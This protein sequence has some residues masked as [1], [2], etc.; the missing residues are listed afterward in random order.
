[1]SKQISPQ[2][3]QA[4]VE[5]WLKTPINTYLGSSY[6]FNK[7]ALL[8]QPLSTATIDEV[9]DKLKRDVPILNVLDSGAINIF[10]IPIPPARMALYLQVGD[11]KFS[12]GVSN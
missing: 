3:I 12:L 10:S 4:M 11:L 8:F 7:S 5:H 2:D 6:G 9:I 1:M